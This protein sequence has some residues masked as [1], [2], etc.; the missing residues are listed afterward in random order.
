MVVL[1]GCRATLRI[2]RFRRDRVGCCLEEGHASAVEFRESEFISTQRGDDAGWFLAISDL[3]EVLVV[4]VVDV[5]SADFLC[6]DDY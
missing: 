2:D 3:L 5:L 6:F 1:R 4:H